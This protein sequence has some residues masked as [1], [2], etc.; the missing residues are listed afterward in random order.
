MRHCMHKRIRKP[1]I[2]RGLI[3][4][5]ILHKEIKTTLSRA[6]KIRPVFERFITKGKALLKAQHNNESTLSL[7]RL[8]IGRL[9]SYS[10]AK[11]LVEEVCT[12]VENREGGYTRIVKCGTM[13]FGD[14]AQPAIISLVRK[15]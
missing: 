12:E 5:L 1:E 9:G 11:T 8:L 4:A 15:N 7:M 3:T 10:L 13:R 2:E 6:K 14:S